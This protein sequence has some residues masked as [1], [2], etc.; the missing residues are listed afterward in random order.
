[1]SSTVIISKLTVVHKS[2]QGI[3]TASAPDVCKT[4]T[5]SGPVPM[6]YPNIAKSSDLTNGSTT[7][8]IDGSPVAIKGCSFATSVGDEAGSLGGVASGITKGQAKFVNYSFDVKIDGKNAC[9]LTDPMTNN[10]NGPNTVTAAETQPGAA[11]P[12]GKLS[13]SDMDDLCRAFCWCDAGKD[14][15]DIVKIVHMQTPPI[16]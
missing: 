8:K 3:A 16:A 6:P 4:S 12:P 1:M 13:P 15:D 9:R 2:S 11:A 7:V 10:G 5:P 14:P